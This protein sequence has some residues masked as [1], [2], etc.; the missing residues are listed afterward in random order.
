MSYRSRF[1]G[2][3]NETDLLLLQLT[4]DQQ[5][6]VD[7][8]VS[9]LD[10]MKDVVRNT[11]RLITAQSNIQEPFLIAKYCNFALYLLVL[12]KNGDQAKIP[13][14]VTLNESTYGLDA[15]LLSQVAFL[16]GYAL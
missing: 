4:S 15:S 13:A 5:R 7:Q 8:I 16:Q 9:G 1:W 12:I 2:R 11:K 10:E 14:W 3:S 6:L